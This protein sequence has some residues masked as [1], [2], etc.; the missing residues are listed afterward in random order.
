MLKEKNIKVNTNLEIVLKVSS[1]N[2]ARSDAEKCKN[3][4]KTQHIVNGNNDE[5]ENIP[6]LQINTGN[7]AQSRNDDRLRLVIRENKS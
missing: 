1:S 4:N 6:V 5:I 2:N 3:H 7:G